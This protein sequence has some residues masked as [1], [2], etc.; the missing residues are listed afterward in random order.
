MIK[1]C[2]T[3]ARHLGLGRC[4][5]NWEPICQNQLWQPIPVHE[6]FA[7]AAR[8][9]CHIGCHGLGVHI[10]ARPDGRYDLRL[11]GFY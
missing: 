4:A 11:E 8:Y 9:V 1:S 7:D 6:T 10:T 3:C 2:S 5:G